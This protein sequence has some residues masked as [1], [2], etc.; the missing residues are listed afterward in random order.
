VSGYYKKSQID[1]E[2]GGAALPEAL[3]DGAIYVGRAAVK[4]DDRGNLSPNINKEGRKDR[5]EG[6]L[7]VRVLGGNV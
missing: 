7:R 6:G 3:G 1:G 5:D 4:T 2:W